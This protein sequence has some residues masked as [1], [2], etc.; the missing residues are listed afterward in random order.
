M[1]PR[2][3]SAGQ[4]RK[5]AGIYTR[6]S[7][8]SQGDSLGVARQEKECR[9]TAALIGAPIRAVYSDDDVSAF[10]TQHRPAYERLL[11]DIAAGAITHVITWHPDRLYRRHHDL[12][13]FID[14]VERAGVSVVTVTAGPLDLGTA[15]GR[16]AARIIGAVAEHESELKSERLRAK[17]DELA[18]RGR[19]PGGTAPFGYRYAGDGMLTVDPAEAEI[20]REAAERVLAGETVRA[21]CRDLNERGISSASGKPWRYTSMKGMLCAPAMTGQRR[22]RD[23][24]VPGCWEP[25]LDDQTGEQLRAELR[26]RAGAT[27]SRTPASLLVGGLLR[28]GRCG[29]A[30]HARTLTSGGRRIYHCKK[31]PDGTGCGRISIRSDRTDAA[32][33]ESIARRLDDPADRAILQALVRTEP[34]LGGSTVLDRNLR[35]LASEHSAGRISRNEWA[36]ARRTLTQTAPELAQPRTTSSASWRRLPSSSKRFLARW[37]SLPLA[38]QRSI[39]GAIIEHIVVRPAQRSVWD[40]ARITDGIVWRSDAKLRSATEHPPEGFTGA[41]GA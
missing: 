37:Q 27:P 24:L 11:R 31:P 5:R 29:C 7:R 1:S 6:I 10:S 34:C 35:A 33:V 17:H 12:V 20:V 2:S 8:D 26:R 3:T 38:T 15:S 18:Q 23:Q 40:P 14:T 36:A 16:M 22:W 25:I 9:R 21:V 28:C 19:W 30:L 41:T 32:V 39:V 4:G 13:R